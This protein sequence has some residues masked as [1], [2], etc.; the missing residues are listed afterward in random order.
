MRGGGIVPLNWATI[1]SGG[2]NDN[3]KSNKEGDDDKDNDGDK[4]GC[5]KWC[6]QGPPSLGQRNACVQSRQVPE[7]RGGV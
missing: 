2:D 5:N 6:I 1:C 7:D 4:G 3:S